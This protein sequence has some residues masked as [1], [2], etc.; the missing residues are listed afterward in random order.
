MNSYNHFLHVLTYTLSFY[1]ENSHQ[2]I[3]FYPWYIVLF[4]R[5]YFSQKRNTEKVFQFQ[6]MTGLRIPYIIVCCWN[7]CLPNLF[8]NDAINRSATISIVLSKDMSIWITCLFIGSSIATHHNHANLE[9][10]LIKVSS[11]I[12]S[13]LFSLV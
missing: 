6:K 4:F 5:W 13:N 11:M 10:I 1:T 3:Q 8:I 2:S 7:R 12:N 9:P